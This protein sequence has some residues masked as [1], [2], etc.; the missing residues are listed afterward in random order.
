MILGISLILENNSQHEIDFVQDPNVKDIET[1][2]DEIIWQKLQKTYLEQE[3]RE[4]YLGQS[5][6]MQEC[7][8]RVSEEQR[9]NPPTETLP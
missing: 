6:A 5:D 9:L 1:Q 3:C 2:R 4:K 7:L 8:D